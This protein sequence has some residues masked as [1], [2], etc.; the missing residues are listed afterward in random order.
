MDILED[1][2]GLILRVDLPGVAPGLAKVEVDENNILSIRAKAS[3]PE[4]KTV[5]MRQFGVGDYFRA[6]QLG[7]NYD[8]DT[9]RAEQSE[10]VLVVTI[11]KRPEARPRHIEIKA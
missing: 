3:L 5:L 11:P 7:P 1:P 8:R 4:P 6:F 2:I 9:I 10:G